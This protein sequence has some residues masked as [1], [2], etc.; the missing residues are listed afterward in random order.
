MLV[1]PG[2]VTDLLKSGAVYGYKRATKMGME[3]IIVLN[4]RHAL[5][6]GFLEP[7]ITKAVIFMM[8][9]V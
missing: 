1:N 5:D 2:A 9:Y 6:Q 3:P 7:D 8:T 4:V